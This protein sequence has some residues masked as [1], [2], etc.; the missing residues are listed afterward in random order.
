MDDEKDPQQR[1]EVL[2]AAL[3]MLVDS[4]APDTPMTD[5]QEDR[6]VFVLRLLRQELGLPQM[7]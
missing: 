3:D 6:Y 7:S 2:T 1:L 5:E 4:L